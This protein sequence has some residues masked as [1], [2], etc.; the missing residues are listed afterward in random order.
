MNKSRFNVQRVKAERL[1]QRLAG[2]IGA[3]TIE[4]PPCSHLPKT[5]LLGLMLLA[6]VCPV[7]AEV[8]DLTSISLED[9]SH[10]TVQT[11]SRR[12]ENLDQAPNT[13]YVITKDQIRER[14]YQRLQDVLQVIPGFGVQHRDLAWVN[15]IR[16]I[17]P[18]DNEKLTLMINGQPV[19]ALTEPQY[20]NG[21]LSLD[22][23]ERIEIVVGPG[24]VMYGS[25]T[26]LATIN[27]ITRAPDDNEVSA[28]IGNAD[29]YSA[30]TILGKK[31]SDRRWF[32]S[33]ITLA[34]R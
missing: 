10:I 6:R 31:W 11:V 8:A 18:N 33:T 29:Q 4:V 3:H 32:N 16:G 22:A 21:A 12:E 20:M 13:I 7:T 26:L 24:S 17:A 30:T 28:N 2:V 15:Q 25:E 27:L 19:N 14:G 1:L 34:T 5:G 9:L 23:V